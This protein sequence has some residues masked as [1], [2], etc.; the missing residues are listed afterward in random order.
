MKRPGTIIVFLAAILLNGQV[1][2]LSAISFDI[3][4]DGY[5]DGVHLEIDPSTG[6]VEG[7]QINVFPT[8]NVVGVAGDILSQGLSVAFSY[9]MP[10]GYWIGSLYTVIRDD[11]TWTNYRNDGNGLYVLNEGTW[12]FGKPG[13]VRKGQ[14]ISSEAVT[15]NLLPGPIPP[16]PTASFDIFFDGYVDGVHLDID[17]SSG[18]VDGYQINV[19]PAGSIVGVAIDVMSQ[20][21]SAAFSYGQ[22]AEYW[23]ATF[24]TVIRNDHTWTDYRNDGSGTHVF[25]EGTWSFGRPGEVRDELPSRFE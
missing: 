17:P 7:Y 24:F 4:Y 6:L 21:L 12:S 14:R 15:G 11:H 13:E 3:Y 20:D 9:G 16:L 23:T 19:W 22:P 2:M 18:L 5:V 25:N 10:A 8:G 1:S